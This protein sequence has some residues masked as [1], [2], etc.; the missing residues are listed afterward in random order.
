MRAIDARCLSVFSVLQ[1]VIFIWM[2]IRGSASQE[3]K[4]DDAVGACNENSRRTC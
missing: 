2:E 3:S 4:A 1:S